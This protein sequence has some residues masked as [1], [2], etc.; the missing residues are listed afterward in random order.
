[1]SCLV[2]L[3]KWQSWV[4]N[5]CF[6]FLFNTKLA[7][8]G[9][10]AVRKPGKYCLCSFCSCSLDT[11]GSLIPLFPANLPAGGSPAQFELISSCGLLT[12][13]H[14]APLQDV[15]RRDQ[16]LGTWLAFCWD[17]NWWKWYSH[18]T[19]EQEFHLSSHITFHILFVLNERVILSLWWLFLCTYGEAHAWVLCWS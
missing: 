10:E 5:D 4:L 9:G 15:L 13:S 1:M 18:D 2:L 17:C 11:Y 16:D 19:E 8:H 12:C 3:T 7:G 14:W 6:T